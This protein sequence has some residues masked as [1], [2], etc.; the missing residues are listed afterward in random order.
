MKRTVIFEAR[1]YQAA[2]DY[3]QKLHDEG[4]DIGCVM[5]DGKI[6]ISWDEADDEE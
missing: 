1:D 5:G 3:A 6:K 2:F 4:H